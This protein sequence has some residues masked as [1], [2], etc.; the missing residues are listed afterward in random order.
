[1][2]QKRLVRSYARPKPAEA[3]HE[4]FIKDDIH[5]RTMYPEISAKPYGLDGEVK[6]GKNDLERLGY[7]ERIKV[8]IYNIDD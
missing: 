1:M 4:D 2:A 7:P 8:V 3:G 5:K 6:L